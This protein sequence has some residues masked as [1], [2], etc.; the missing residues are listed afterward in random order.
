MNV[1]HMPN[2]P[3]PSAPCQMPCAEF[4]RVLV[5]E[6]ND[7]YP[8]P[9]P[10]HH[11]HNGD[12]PHPLVP[13]V[14]LVLTRHRAMKQE[15]A[16]LA[17]PPKGMERSN[18]TMN[19]GPRIWDKGRGIIGVTRETTSN[20]RYPFQELPSRA[21]S[22]LHPHG[23]RGATAP[24]EGKGAA[25]RSHSVLYM[26]HTDGLGASAWP[27]K[28]GQAAPY[29]VETHHTG[30]HTATTRPKKEKRKRHRQKHYCGVGQG[31]RHDTWVCC[32]L[33]LAAPIGLSP[34]T[35]ALLLNPSRRRQGRPS[36]SHLCVLPLPAWPVLT[37][38]HRARPRAGTGHNTRGTQHRHNAWVT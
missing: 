13:L 38:L 11:V 36:A 15:Q 7:T 3:L 33:Q 37:S 6:N 19:T 20:R 9:C 16:P 31:G 22:I 23:H 26:G 2:C 5:P 24:P 21:G 25:A 32:C 28:R 14:P 12:M 30:I 34:L 10:N 18:Q 29:W 8:R 17:Q 27:D 35:G 4:E 1:D